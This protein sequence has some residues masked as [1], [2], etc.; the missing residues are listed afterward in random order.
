MFACSAYKNVRAKRNRD[1]IKA[2]K[3]TRKRDGLKKNRKRKARKTRNRKKKKKKKVE[4]ER[5]ETEIEE[6][7]MHIL[8]KR[9]IKN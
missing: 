5:M 2:R 3:K 9:C 6:V 8:R 4:I 7:T 1:T